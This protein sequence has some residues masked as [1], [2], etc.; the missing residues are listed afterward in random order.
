MPGRFV[1]SSAG[2]EPAEY[3]VTVPDATNY[4]QGSYLGYMSPWGKGSLNT[5]ADYANYLDVN[6]ATWPNGSR[7]RTRWPVSGAPVAVWGYMF[8]GFGKYD[9]ATVVPDPVDPIQMGNL[10]SFVQE[11][12]WS[13]TG[14]PNFILLNELYLT[15]LEGVHTPKEVEVAFILHAAAP[16]ITWHNTGAD[17]GTYVDD[18]ARSWSV[19]RH[20]GGAASNYIHLLPST[21]V[22]ILSGTIN[23]KHALEWLVGQGHVEAD[24]WINGVAI[25][26]EPITNAGETTLLI[27]Q[28]EVTE[29]AAGA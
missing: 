14:S 2:S 7:I 17:Y 29:F 18:Q 28:F 25:G 21:P 15:T 23:W 20:P 8:I 10:G 5:P 24:W 9:G 19:R 11:F 3:D 27:N 4:L 13:Y 1:L 26:S 22:D 6:T 16:T 12:D